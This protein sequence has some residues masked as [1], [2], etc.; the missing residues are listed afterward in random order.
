MAE[1][2]DD[3][4]LREML[5]LADRLCAG[6]SDTMMSGQYAFL[7]ARIDALLEL[8]GAAE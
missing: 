1:T 5:A 8:R 3:A 4:I 6:T 2:S 7:R